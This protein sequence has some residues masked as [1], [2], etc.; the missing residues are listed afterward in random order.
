[1]AM[2]SPTETLMSMISASVR[3]SPG[4]VS[5]IWTI[6]DDEGL[7][8]MAVILSRGARPSVLEGPVDGVEHPVEVGEVGVL[9][10]RRRVGGVVAAHAQHRRLEVVEALFGHA[11]GDLDRK[12][13]RLNS[14]HVA[15]SYAV[16][17]LKKK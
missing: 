16:F 12:S 3:P 5:L 6:D 13:T 10:P 17:C 1:M 4:S 11:R 9:H 2:V 8:L 15:I 14:S 7:W